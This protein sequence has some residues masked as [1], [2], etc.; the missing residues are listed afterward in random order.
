[1]RFF[2]AALHCSLT[3]R[4][5]KPRSYLGARRRIL[6]ADPL[7]NRRESR[8]FRTGQAQTRRQ[9]RARDAVLSGHVFVFG[10]ADAGLRASMLR[11]R[12]ALPEG[13]IRC[14]WR[15]G[16]IDGS[17]TRLLETAF[18]QSRARLVKMERPTT[19]SQLA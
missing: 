13:L 10:E 7:A 2:F 11:R 15:R 3:S 12:T 4:R 18:W 1:M 8:T 16:T 5:T 17:S 19:I 6:A 14:S 9:M